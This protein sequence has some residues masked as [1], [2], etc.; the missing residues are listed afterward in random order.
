[1]CMVKL[2]LFNKWKK[3]SGSNEIINNT[4]KSIVL[5]VEYPIG[6][7]T[8]KIRKITKVVQN[9]KWYMDKKGSYDALLIFKENI[10]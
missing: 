5:N 7:H 2:W 4:N 1:M 8:N 6:K 9:G 3:K 10:S